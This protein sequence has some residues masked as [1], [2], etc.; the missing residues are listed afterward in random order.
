MELPLGSLADPLADPVKPLPLALLAVI[1]SGQVVLA[2]PFGPR[3][4][5]ATVPT[6]APWSSSSARVPGASFGLG[7][8]NGRGCW[9]TN[10]V[11]LRR[12][13]RVLFRI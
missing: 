5:P 12:W 11:S 13:S 7:S 10:H 6:A 4:A 3:Q 8:R 9:S 1:T 2:V